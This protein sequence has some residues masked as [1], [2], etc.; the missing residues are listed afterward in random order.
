MHFPEFLSSQGSL[1]ELPKKYLPE[2]QNAEVKQQHVFILTI[3]K[4]QVSFHTVSLICS[5][6]SGAGQLP[7]SQIRRPHQTSFFGFSG[8]WANRIGNPVVKGVSQVY[9]SPVTRRLKMVSDR[10][11]LVHSVVFVS[12]LSLGVPVC[13]YASSFY[14]HLPFTAARTAWFKSNTRY[15]SNILTQTTQSTST[16]I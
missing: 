7:F 11:H 4:G 6:P 16:M 13:S 15:R 3:G 2:I 5:Y 12:I 10:G 9:G 1:L 14:V 8:S